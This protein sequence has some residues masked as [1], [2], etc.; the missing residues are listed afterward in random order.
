MSPR[1]TQVLFLA[2]GLASWAACAQ[3]P[4]A[5]PAEPRFDVFEFR[6]EGNTVLPVE[7]IER[8]VYPFLGEKKAAAD[9]ESARVALEAAYRGAG[10][11]TVVVDTPEQRIVDGV[12]TLQVVQAPVARLRVVGSRYY[13]QG[14]ILEAVP[15]LAEGQVPNFQAA[16]AQL[17]AVN[18]SAD[19]RVTPLLRPGKAPGTTEVDLTVED[20]PPL[21]ASLA[22]DNKYSANTTQTRLNASVR[23][24]NLW[25]L[26]HSL[27][28]QVQLSPQDT[29]QVKVFSG[30]Y[31]VPTGTGLV[32]ASAIR[33]NSKTVAGVGSTTVF[34]RGNI[35]GLRDILL[36]EG[37]ET[38]SRVL[39]LGVDY[40]DF[41][42]SVSVGAN[43]GFDTPIHYLPWSLNYSKTLGSKEGSWQFGGGITFALRGVGSTESQFADKRYK[44]QSNF[45]I[46]KIDA[47]RT[48]NLGNSGMTFVG[49]IEGQLSDQALISNEQFV[50]GGVDSVRGYLEAAAVG[51][52]AL[53][54]SFELRSGN[55]AP[56]AWSWLGDV[57]AHAFVE[58]AGLWLNDPLPAQD[59]RFGLLGTG[60]GLRIRALERASVSLDLAWPLHDSGSVRKGDLRV[61]ASGAID[62]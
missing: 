14:R 13:S 18:R 5:A 33:S 57:R 54:A 4:S 20:Q 56:K 52:K 55:L 29:S 39:T 53:R 44:A 10:Y 49:R 58:G 1:L 24:D 23:Y 41:Q 21:H 62:F 26:E 34:G 30:S 38:E 61:H 37:S 2:C 8:A 15:A 9:V 22:L 32:V 42:E 16:T 60:V 36:L 48:L 35:Y 7:A 51:D 45:A 46:L 19:R 6:V 40:K 50:A 17:A 25:Q 31:T 43:E 47:T 59:E 3:E 12:V 11:G 28:L 27:G